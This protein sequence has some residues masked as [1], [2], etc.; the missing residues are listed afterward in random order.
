[1]TKK[2]LLL[3]CLLG[4]LSSF[5]AYA[6]PTNKKITLTCNSISTDVITA[7][8]AV[9]LTDGGALSSPCGL[10]FCDSS[11]ASAPATNSA[12]CT[13]PFRVHDL[14]YTLSYVDTDSL[15]NVSQSGTSG[16]ALVRGNGFSVQ[17]TASTGD[18]VTLDVK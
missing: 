18:T 5:P 13:T 10:I 15:G 2:V 8:V 16:I 3:S 12:S 6:S 1:M 9:T 14:S 4:L 11:G 17:S 7:N